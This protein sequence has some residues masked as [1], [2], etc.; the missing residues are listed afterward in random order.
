MW[1]I[2]V[3][4]NNSSNGISVRALAPAFFLIEQ[5]QPCEHA[6]RKKPD[7]LCPLLP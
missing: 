6:D 1:I 4:A 5:P 7:T 3:P 2:S